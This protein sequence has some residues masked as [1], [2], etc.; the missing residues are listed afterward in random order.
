ME[1]PVS[2][3]EIERQPAAPEIDEA[4]LPGEEIEAPTETPED[5]AHAV[6][7]EVAIQS[8]RDALYWFFMYLN[9]FL[10]PTTKE[11]LVWISS[12]DGVTKDLYEATW[13]PR[14]AQP[15]QRASTL[16]ALLQ[17]NLVQDVGGLFRITER[18]R[19]YKLFLAGRIE[20]AL[21]ATAS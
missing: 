4:N 1:D 13:G 3:G 21:G 12:L 10:V 9:L 11:V 14:L 18:G 8:H 16:N 15:I 6:L 19:R 2:G 7:W 5:E 20:E 17:T